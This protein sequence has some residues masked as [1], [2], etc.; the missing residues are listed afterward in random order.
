MSHFSMDDIYEQARSISKAGQFEARALLMQA[1]L[2]QVA[3]EFRRSLRFQVRKIIVNN[4]AVP[5]A[6]LEDQDPLDWRDP[7]L[8]PFS[9]RMVERS[10]TACT[11]QEEPV[12][13]DSLI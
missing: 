4:Y 5:T 1:T 10:K 2:P 8:L 7:A 6:G 11:K 3:S 9:Q 12:C 13:P